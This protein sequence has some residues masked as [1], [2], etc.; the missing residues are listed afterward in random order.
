MLHPIF[1][2]SFF[3][4]RSRGLAQHYRETT[5]RHRSPHQDQA[6]D[7]RGQRGEERREEVQRGK[8]II[9][10]HAPAWEGVFSFPGPKLDQR[11][12][13]LPPVDHRSL[14]RPAQ[15]RP[16]RLAKLTL[17]LRHHRGGHDAAAG[18][19]STRGDTELRAQDHKYRNVE[20]CLWWRR[21]SVR[22]S[23][24]TSA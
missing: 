1:L 22:G 17:A 19:E 9:L 16:A 3:D 4:L 11:K 10:S 6:T 15:P 13:L 12:S 2:S 24:V 23:L 14:G 8:K 21:T 20:K 7:T 5:L 18:D